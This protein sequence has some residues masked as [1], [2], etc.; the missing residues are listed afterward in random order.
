MGVFAGVGP[1]ASTGALLLLA[2]PQAKPPLGLAVRVALRKAHDFP[3]F[4]PAYIWSHDTNF[5]R[6]APGAGRSPISLGLA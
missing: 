5:C 3:E 1:A 4:A 2:D 6:D